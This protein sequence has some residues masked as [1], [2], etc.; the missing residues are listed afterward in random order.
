VTLSLSDQGIDLLSGVLAAR[1][2]TGEEELDVVITIG[3]VAGGG[4]TLGMGWGE[5]RMPRS[6]IPCVQITLLIGSTTKN[7]QQTRPEGGRPL[8]RPIG[9]P[10][11]GCPKGHYN[12]MTPPLN[13]VCLITATTWAGVAGMTEN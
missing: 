3:V 13:G 4:A 7:T 2:A 5:G 10:G 8:G 1:V 9:R 11:V 12:V 6:G